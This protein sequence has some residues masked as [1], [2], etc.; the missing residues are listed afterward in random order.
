M[1]CMKTCMRIVAQHVDINMYLS[2]LW[3]CPIQ[4]KGKHQKVGGRQV[5]I[6]QNAQNIFLE[7]DS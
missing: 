3:V 7:I 1:H 2:K 6:L 4:Q 5:N